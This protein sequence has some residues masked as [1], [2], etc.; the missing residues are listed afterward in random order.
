MIIC[1]AVGGE[2]EPQ[3][4]AVLAELIKPSTVGVERLCEAAGVS[5]QYAENLRQSGARGTSDVKG[6][7]KQ[8]EEIAGKCAYAQAKA[9]EAGRLY[10]EETGEKLDSSGTRTLILR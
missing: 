5:K 9:A 2:L 1:S 10:Q 8:L 6:A 3:R 4:D 7:L